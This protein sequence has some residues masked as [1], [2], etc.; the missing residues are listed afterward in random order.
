MQVVQVI[1]SG[2][3]AISA[4]Y[5]HSMV[6][7]QDGSV[8]A[9]GRNNFGQLGTQ[10]P[11]KFRTTFVQ[12]I[13]GDVRAIAAGDWH[14]M[15][16][17]HDGSLWATGKNLYG[18]LGDGSMLSQDT[19]VRLLLPHDGLWCMLLLYFPKVGPIELSLV[20]LGLSHG[21]TIR[22]CW[23]SC[24]AFIGSPCS[25]NPIKHTSLFVCTVTRHFGKQ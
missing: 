25:H 24:A 4:G 22:V 7:K 23:Y 16:L 14:S 11:N 20:K 3:K 19:F 2:A 10:P 6:L 13:S 1:S 5:E 17:K 8:W 9:T 18:Q 21:C 15:V 12:V